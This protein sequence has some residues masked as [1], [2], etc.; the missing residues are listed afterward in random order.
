MNVKVFPNPSTGILYIQASVTV[1]VKLTTIDG[2]LL[3]DQKNAN[4]LDMN[5]YANGIYFISVYDSNSG[6][7]I[8]TDRIVKTG[9]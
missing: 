2:R 1:D 6:N 5:Y 3:I 8:K 4:Q 9:N 7:L